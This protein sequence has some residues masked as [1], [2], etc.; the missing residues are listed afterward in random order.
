VSKPELQGAIYRVR[1]TGAAKVADAFGNQI[2]WA[3]LEPANVTQYLEDA[4]P[5]VCERAVQ[6]L[7]AKGDASV[8]VLTDVLRN[9]RA[10]DART[11]AVFALYQ[12]GTANALASVRTALS[13]GGIQVRVAAARSAGLARDAQAVNRLKE[14]IAKDEPAVRRQAATA[15][16][17]IGD[18]SA[19]SALLAAA[20]SADDRF[21]QHAI[22][23]SLISLNQSDIVA[24]GLLH[25]SPKVREVALITLDQMPAS[26][27]QADQLTPFL[28]S[29]NTGL[30]STAL[31]VASHHAEW[32]GDMA[33]F[34]SSRF[35]GPSLSDEEKE[36]FE[37]ILVSFCGNATMQQFM[38][39][40]VNNTTKE[41]KLFLLGAMAKCGVKEI[42]QVWVDQIGQQ[43]LLSTDP[44]V[45]ARAME[46]V[47]LRG[48]TS[49]TN[50]LRKVADNTKNTASLRI[51][52]LGA[53][54]KT[55]PQFTDS[56]FA[57]LYDR[58]KAANEA[59]IRQQAAAVLAQGKL[60]EKQLL[61]LAT[62]YLPQA[63]AFILPRLVPVFQGAQSPEIGKAL[64][65]T[66]LTSPSLDSFNEENMQAL[67][68]NYP[69]EV[70]PSVEQLMTKLRDVQASRLKRLKEMEARIA[71]GDLERGRKLFFGKAICWTCHKV[72]A[73]GGKL[74]PDLTS[75]Q[76]DRSAHD[77]LEAI[78]YPSVSFVR[79]FETYRIKT[80]TS[81][82][83]GIIQEQTPTALVLGTS[84]QTS[85]R[86][87]REEIVSME[88]SN[89]SMM[90][91]GL[92]QLLTS[93]EMTDLMA[94]ILGQDQDPDTDRSILR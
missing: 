77:L 43:L 28:T 5:F 27:L 70:N 41:N 19:A 12:I 69:A 72:G 7:V 46:L 56:H 78:V 85:V 81:D 49:L 62:E 18:K 61:K 71:D 67:F 75:I 13:D 42:P 11:K 68:A 37:Q 52:A 38:A 4:R 88:I 21:V 93:Q 40:Q 48:I 79:E 10:E 32:S 54:L 59:P 45:Q 84:P 80:K 63:D 33:K 83:T 26:P 65:A 29:D 31:W 58:L 17:Q 64:S 47:R 6:W 82:Y 30:R 76:R 2:K 57:Y 34:L 86:I 44:Q 94:F 24:Q 87:P 50:Q 92:D 8:S 89:V 73:D 66:L 9:S 51:E 36:L 15:L 39:G 20:E 3:S 23:Y 35:K 16:G 1:R 55:Q 60:S 90:P 74:G 25:A 14:I 22:I 91:Q 53:L